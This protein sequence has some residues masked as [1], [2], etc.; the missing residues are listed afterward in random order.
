MTE[1]TI[2]TAIVHYGTPRVWVE[3]YETNDTRGNRVV[4]EDFW[5]NGPAFACVSGAKFKKNGEL[6]SRHFS[7]LDVKVPANVLVKLAE[8]QAELDAQEEVAS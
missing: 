6:N 1:P 4:V 3:K 2:T 5:L 8:L 7:N